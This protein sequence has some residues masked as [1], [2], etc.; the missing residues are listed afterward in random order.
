[1]IVLSA[2][3]HTRLLMGNSDSKRQPLVCHMTFKSPF[4]TNTSMM[5]HPGIIE[6]MREALYI[7]GPAVTTRPATQ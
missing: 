2:R 7:V 3:F 6:T 5:P 1:M 4:I